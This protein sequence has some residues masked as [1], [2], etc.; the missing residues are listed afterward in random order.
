MSMSMFLNDLFCNS[1]EFI[2]ISVVCFFLYPYIHLYT[3][4]YLVL[5]QLGCVV[6]HHW[7]CKLVSG[8]P[9]PC[10]RFHVLEGYIL[11]RSVGKPWPAYH[12]V[13]TGL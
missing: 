12:S 9:W 11:R 3:Y 5:V 8:P 13:P 6:A 1:R 7:R 10:R 4:V 2:S